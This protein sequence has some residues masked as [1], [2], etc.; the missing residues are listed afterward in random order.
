MGLELNSI[1]KI[2]KKTIY[3]AQYTA[4]QVVKFAELTLKKQ[5]NDRTFYLSIPAKRYKLDC[6]VKIGQQYL[7][8]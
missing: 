1:S 4:N 8:K 3:C 2:N 6:P 7:S 5:I